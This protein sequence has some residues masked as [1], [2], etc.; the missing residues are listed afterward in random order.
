MS[1]FKLYLKALYY[2]I[3]PTRC[4]DCHI[5]LPAFLFPLKNWHGIN[6]CRRC[7]NKMYKGDPLEA[8]YYMHF[9][10]VGDFIMH[11]KDSLDF[12]KERE[13]WR[14]YEHKRD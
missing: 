3:E 6:N 5:I 7:W 13:V 4:T 12:A 8:D 11:F 10:P 1:K 9:N 14:K 2:N